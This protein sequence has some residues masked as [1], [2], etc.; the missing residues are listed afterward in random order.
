MGDSEAMSAVKEG[1]RDLLISSEQSRTKAVVVA[2]RD[3][4]PGI[5]PEH[6]ER[7][8]EAFYTTKS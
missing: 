7:V 5:D 8:F 1:T 3:S 4:G 6:I 2:V